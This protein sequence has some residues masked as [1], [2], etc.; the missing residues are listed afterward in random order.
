MQPRRLFL[1]A[2]ERMPYDNRRYSLD[3]PIFFAIYISPAT[4]MSSLFL[5][6]F[7]YSHLVA[8]KGGATACKF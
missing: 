4:L 3:L 1:H 2:A 5:N 6:V 8:R 7:F